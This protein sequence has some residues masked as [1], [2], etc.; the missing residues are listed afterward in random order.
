[1]LS[2]CSSGWPQAHCVAQTGFKPEILTSAS[3]V[4]GYQR[5]TC[6]T[7]EGSISG[8]TVTARKKASSCE[9]SQINDG[10]CQLQLTKSEMT[11]Q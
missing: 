11:P 2:F 3:P 4:L 10:P 8:A 5:H 1:M 9:I 6:L 7:K